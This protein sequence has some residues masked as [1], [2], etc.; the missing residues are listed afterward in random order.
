MTSSNNGS[1]PKEAKNNRLLLLSFNPC[2]FLFMAIRY[3]LDASK[4]HFFKKIL[5]QTPR[6]QIDSEEISIWIIVH[7]LINMTPDPLNY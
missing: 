7:V 5:W 1:L 3:T 4:L 6:F 2:H